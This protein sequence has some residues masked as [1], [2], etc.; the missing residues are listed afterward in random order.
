M[1]MPVGSGRRPEARRNPKV[2]FG[3]PCSACSLLGFPSGCLWGPSTLALT[4]P[5]FLSW[6]ENWTGRG[7]IWAGTKSIQTASCSVWWGS[8]RLLAGPGSLLGPGS[9]VVSALLCARTLL[10]APPPLVSCMELLPRSHFFSSGFLPWL[11]SCVP[12]LV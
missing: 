3:C 5:L 2:G 1:L 4:Q 6:S 8:D 7:G 12:S 9:P 11:V 10:P